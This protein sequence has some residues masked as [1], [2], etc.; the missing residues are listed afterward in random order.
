MFH[1]YVNK[2]LISGRS[3][4]SSGAL[5]DHPTDRTSSGALEDRPTLGARPPYYRRNS[6]WCSYYYGGFD[7]VFSSLLNQKVAITTP[8]FGQ[9]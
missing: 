5:D 9:R 8:S 2:T 4:V 7:A 3:R 6:L 1:I